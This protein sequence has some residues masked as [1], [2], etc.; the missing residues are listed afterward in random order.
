M[1]YLNSALICCNSCDTEFMAKLTDE[2]IRMGR[3]KRYCPECDQL[4]ACITLYRAKEAN[5]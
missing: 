5:R 4:R 3:C 1:N 2:E